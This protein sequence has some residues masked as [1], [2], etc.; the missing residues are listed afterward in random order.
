MSNGMSLEKARLYEQ[1]RLPYPATMVDDLLEQIGTPET[2]ADIGAG[3]GQL[4]RLFAD[5]CGTVYAVEPD[6]AMHR[7]ATE[8]LQGYS[9]IHIVHAA[10]E[11]TTLPDNSIDLLVIGNAFHRFRPDAIAELLRILKPDGWAALT[12][13]IFTNQA[14]SDQLFPKL[15][16]L[17]SMAARSAQAVHRLPMTALF[18]DHPIRT[19]RYPQT[20]DEDWTA[21]WGSARSGIEA[22]LPGEEDFAAFEAINREV[23]TS[24]GVDGRIRMEYETRVDFGQPRG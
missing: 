7:V 10:A 19:L 5:H 9:N 17:K 4:S 8:A 12:A 23:F 24:F 14:F 1:Y 22:P 21:F 11:Q 16:A 18:G 15:G 13:Y 20:F 6:E 3:T 2:I